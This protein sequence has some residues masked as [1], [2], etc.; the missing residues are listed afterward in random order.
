MKRFTIIAKDPEDEAA[1]RRAMNADGAYA[2]LWDIS[3]E[4]F[5]PARK[6]GYSGCNNHIQEL[7]DKIDAML[8]GSSGELIR[9]L[10][11][12]FGEILAEHNVN[13]STD[14]N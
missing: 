13:L 10:E 6:H 2:A 7:C 4:V 11:E 5:R 12:K 9:F 3:N 1:M 14:W 8:P